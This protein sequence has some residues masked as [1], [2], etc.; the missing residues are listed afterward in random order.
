M[1]KN[2]FKIIT[3]A[4]MILFIVVSFYG[5]SSKENVIKIATKPMS[6][7]FILGEMLGILI[8]EKTDLDVEI[9]KGIAGGTGNIHPA[10]IKG[11]FDMYPEYTGTSW[12]FVLKE[13]E[14][15]DDEKKLFEEINKKYKEEF[16]LEWVGLYGFN[17]TF[18]IVVKDDIAEK[19]NLEKASE[20]AKYSDELVF[21]AEYDYYEREDG[22][23]VLCEEYGFNFK[24][25]LDI[26]IG[27]KYNAINN[28]EID[29]MLVFTTDGQLA[30]ANVKVLEDDKNFHKTYHCGTVVRQE[31]LEK[32]DGWNFKS[33]RNGKIKL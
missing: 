24:E 15:L 3:K 7:Q 10:L 17:N 9:T 2:K 11:D 30:E 8:E 5:C 27:L 13:T 6:E 4:I 16:E 19:Y 31:T 33:R 21:G 22:Y 1:K 14:I 12:T 26:D 23:Y 20:L 28:G 25:A 18:G 29:T 32:H